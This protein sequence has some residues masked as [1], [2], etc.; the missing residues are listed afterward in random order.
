MKN[1]DHF[2]RSI[3]RLSSNDYFFPTTDLYNLTCK[4][5][6]NDE[7]DTQDAHESSDFLLSASRF[8]GRARRDVKNIT[9]DVMDN[10]VCYIGVHDNNESSS[11]LVPLM[12]KMFQT[13]LTKLT[14]AE[15]EFSLGHRFRTIALNWANSKIPKSQRGSSANNSFM[16]VSCMDSYGKVSIHDHDASTYLK[17]LPLTRNS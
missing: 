1:N 13:R 10:Y 6:P 8:S 15:D 12:R 9:D 16:N 14:G 3:R 2:R 4:K 7:S 11:D 17:S 5:V